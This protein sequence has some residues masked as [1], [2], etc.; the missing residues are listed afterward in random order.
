MDELCNYGVITNVLVQVTTVKDR[1]AESWIQGE[2]SVLSTAPTLTP[3]YYGLTTTTTHY[4]TSITQR[5][6]S[7]WAA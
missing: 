2:A 1:R 7:I 5:G 6:N 3:Y 4:F